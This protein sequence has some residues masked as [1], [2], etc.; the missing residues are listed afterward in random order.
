MT[1]CYDTM[2]Q[3]KRNCQ[4]NDHLRTKRLHKSPDKV[5]QEPSKKRFN[6]TAK[7]LRFSEKEQTLIAPT[8]TIA[9]T[10][11]TGGV[12]SALPI[13]TGLPTVVLSTFLTPS[14][15][16]ATSTPATSTFTKPNTGGSKIKIAVEYP[17]KTLTIQCQRQSW[18]HFVK[19]SFTVHLLESQRQLSSGSFSL[20]WPLFKEETIPSSK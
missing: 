2:T 9:P 11:E 3:I 13:I 17:S 20:E 7:C 19:L 15:P 14:V 1:H 4:G 6:S 18:N 16:V 5:E 8:T 10:I 12:I